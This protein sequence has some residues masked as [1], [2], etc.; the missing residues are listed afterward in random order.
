MRGGSL[1]KINDL[2]NKRFGKLIVLY[3]SKDHESKN[4]NK[5]VVWHCKCDC[6]NEI[7]VMALN[8]T[9]NHTT[10]CGC[11]RMDSIN[12]NIIKDITGQR[13]GNLV[14]IKR[15]KNIKGKT[16]WLFKCDCGNEIECYLSNV[17][18]GKTKTCGKNCKLKNHKCYTNSKKGIRQNL[19]GQRFGKLIV[20]EQLKDKNGW[21]QFRCVC[22]CGN[23]KIAS[24]NNLKYGS[25]KSCGC[26]KKE[27]L[28]HYNYEDLIGKKFGK[29]LVIEMSYSK[30]DK[31]HWLCQCDCGNKTTVSTSGLKSGHTKSC[32]CHQDET[33]SNVH[34]VDLTNH[35]F[36][37]LT[38][39]KR[40]KN[41]NTGIVRYLC[42]C[43]CG[44]YTTVA[45]G[46][47]TSGKIQSCG[48]W[49]YSKI[50][51][52]VRKYLVSHNYL[53]NIDFE[54]QKKFANLVGVGG[55]RLSYDFIIYKN[56]QPFYLIECQGQQHYYPVDYFGGKE[57]FKIQKIHDQLKKKYAKK[58]GV[59][60]LEIPYTINN[61]KK[62]SNL[63]SQAGI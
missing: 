32:G 13:F 6:G 1:S 48:C 29:L 26:L 18:T 54:C 15:V 43:E 24:G 23:E 31:L 16:K 56:K 28:K 22:D 45:G 25:T 30:Y 47:L 7:D 44:N 11:A 41:S 50:E 21:T 27:K 5:R 51:E 42:Q 52:E 36:G 61:Y 35:T 53:N 12:K 39:V 34:F 60:L 4:G 19:T 3:R 59:P 49:K 8:L 20:V 2:R 46:H 9:R 14:G 58:I 37:K 62:L 17:T 38:V 63:L 10:S 57:K 55:K 33:A 40:V